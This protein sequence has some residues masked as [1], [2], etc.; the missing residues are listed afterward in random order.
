MIYSA[1]NEIRDTPTNLPGTYLPMQNLIHSLDSTRPV[2]FAIYAHNETA[3]FATGIQTQMDV[4]GE[5]Y[6]AG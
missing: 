6:R 3:I 5:N 1:G 2:T 4:V